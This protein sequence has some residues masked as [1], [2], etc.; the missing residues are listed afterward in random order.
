MIT[1]EFPVSSQSAAETELKAI[2]SYRATA[3]FRAMARLKA[4]ARLRASAR[5]RVS[6]RRSNEISFIEHG[7]NLEF[8]VISQMATETELYIV[9]S[10]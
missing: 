3:C 1:P 4:T 2:V 6:A 8:P 10:F 5:L 7:S 9:I